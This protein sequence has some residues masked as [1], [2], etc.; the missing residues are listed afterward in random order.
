MKIDHV[1]IYTSDLEGMR[2]FFET[3]FGAGAGEMYHNPR[4]GL[5][6]Y[7]LTFDS[8]ARLEIMSRPEVLRDMRQHYGMGLTHISF[9]V[10]S[11]EQVDAMTRRLTADGYTLLDG[12]RTTGDGYY[13]CAI[14]GPEELYIEIVE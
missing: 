4:T 13:E 10:G 6:S 2:R 14:A 12:P 11:K 5:C 9:S 3:Y 7:F 1:A 8:G